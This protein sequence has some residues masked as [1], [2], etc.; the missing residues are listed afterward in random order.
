LNYDP[1]DSDPDGNGAHGAH[2]AGIAVG[3]GRSGGPLGLA[4][5]A[6]IVFV[7]LTTLNADDPDLADS[8]SVLEAIDF[9]RGVAGSRPWVVNLSMGQCGDQHDG[10]TLIEQGLD[11]ALTEAPGRA[12]AQSAG[13]YFASRQHS[14]GR[15]GAGERRTLTWRAPPAEDGN[16]L[17]IWYPG[18]DAFTVSLR[19]P[20]GRLAGRASLGERVQLTAGGR[21]CGELNNR[22]RDPNNLDNHVVM[23]LT[24]DAPPGDWRLT[25]DGDSV[26]DGAYHLWIQRGDDDGGAQ[27]AFAAG[28]A[29]PFFT[30]NSICNGRSTIVAGAYDARSERRN[31][32][33]FSSSGP[34]RDG[35]LKPDLLAPG[36]GVL[37][38]RSTPAG[39]PPGRG[40]Q[41]RM[42]GTS[43]A[44]P[45]VAGAIA[46]M[47][48][49]A[50]RPLR[51]EETRRLLI[52]SVQ[53]AERTDREAIRYGEGYLDV[54]AAV[55]AARKSVEGSAPL[56]Q[57]A[58]EM[59]A[60][61]ART[62]ANG[63]T[64]DGLMGL[65]SLADAL[66]GRRGPVSQ[67]PH[68]LLVRVLSD[69]ADP[70][71]LNPAIAAGLLDPA[72]LFDGFAVARL[73]H[74]RPLLDRLFAVVAYP[75]QMLAGP[76]RAGDLMVRR[77]LG[78]P[79]MGHAAF[80][81]G[82]GVYRSHD[83][84]RR[85]FAPE[86][87]RPGLFAHVVEAGSQPHTL[88][89]RFARRIASEEGLA[90][91]DTLI[92]RPRLAAR[93][94][95]RVARPAE[96]KP[97]GV[98]YAAKFDTIRGW[99]S[100]GVATDGEIS[101]GA[102]AEPAASANVA[103]LAQIFQLAQAGSQ[104]VALLTGQSILDNGTVARAD[105]ADKSKFQMR[106]L[107]RICYPVDPKSPDRIAGTTP[108]PVVAIVHGNH[109]NL[110]FSGW[111]PTGGLVE[112]T[113]HDGTK[114]SYPALKTA[115]FSELD[116][117]LGYEY[118][119]TELAKNGIASI[120]IDNNILNAIGTYLDGRA[121]MFLATLDEWRR[122]VADDAKNPCHGML[123]FESNVGFLGHSRGGDAVV[124]A[125]KK[126]TG[127]NRDNRFG[128]KAVCSLSPTDFTGSAPK[129]AMAMLPSDAPLVDDSMSYLV[130][131]G[132]LDGDVKGDSVG[133]RGP[134]ESFAGTGFRLYDRAT[135][136]KAMVF[137]KGACHNRFN[138]N[139]GT[140]PAVIASDPDLLTPDD[141]LEAS[142]FYIGGFFRWQLRDEFAFKRRFTGDDKPPGKI[143]T[144]IQWSGGVQAALRLGEV[145]RI[146]TFEDPAKNEFGVARVTPFGNIITFGEL[147]VNGVPQGKSIPYQTS[148]LDADLTVAIPG[149]QVLVETLPTPLTANSDWTSFDFL[150]F[151][152]GRWFD[153]TKKPFKGAPP[154]VQVTLKDSAGMEARATEADFLP[155]NTP[156]L[157][158]PHQAHQFDST[159]KLLPDPLQLTYQRLE[160]VRVP[161]SLFKKGG[162]DLSNVQS[163]SLSLE[164]KDNTHVFIDSLELISIVNL[165]A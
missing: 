153:L 45:H 114:V 124:R 74:L 116:S 8:A 61:A 155:K 160:T 135:C 94:A 132:A 71:A 147:E 49:A 16:E 84:A 104:T 15:L 22:R 93:T 96:Q 121:E 113:Y 123:D 44:A 154:H 151:R 163:V 70:A 24:A 48:E 3:N 12:I 145:R 146:D 63:A 78:E 101:H 89:H 11:A 41:V 58:S 19:S 64:Q 118:L 111:T 53:S 133:T 99:S 137:V 31:V 36:V 65:V 20:D 158:F 126:N 35:R 159:G 157:P 86:R 13:N 115:T 156:G 1:A 27:A 26:K 140:E 14:S 107:G 40:L 90:P 42:T 77:A 88:A 162:I 39:A 109:T 92:L 9:I 97:P 33:S 127:R 28:E 82:D 85:G 5:Q 30:T 56:S 136:E 4:P 95:A 6:D 152:L 76:L 75:R 129:S 91:A 141:H 138:T 57:R 23:W 119:Q 37:S 60:E 144:A 10:T 98:T 81:A 54:D 47:F 18:A 67:S 52:G 43:M 79:G 150:M 100:I 106:L 69:F 50:P 149:P 122:Q 105:G 128:L 87:M 164:K 59:P 21:S 83:A 102:F 51:I 68:A 161:L 34:T 66:I 62:T 139:W 17:E 125:A 130:V 134:F 110:Q 165:T 29:N 25:L 143:T 148:I 108:A 103:D 80:I 2:V 73:R 38:A 7:Q 32:A 46:L 131:Y 72:M 117:Y 55:Q 120:S 112:V 142:K